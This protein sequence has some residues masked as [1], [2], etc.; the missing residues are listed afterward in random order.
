MPRGRSLP[1]GRAAPTEFPTGTADL[2]A[3]SANDGPFR[4]SCTGPETT[5]HISIIQPVA[6]TATGDVVINENDGLAAGNVQSRV[7]C[8]VCSHRTLLPQIDHFPSARIAKLL[9]CLSRVIGRAIVGDNHFER[10]ALLA[11]PREARSNTK[12]GSRTDFASE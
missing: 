4:V 1:F 8:R 6:C 9:H 2:L 12:P 11:S 7:S 3:M 10:P 5:G